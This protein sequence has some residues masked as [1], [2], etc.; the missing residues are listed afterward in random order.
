MN[1]FACVSPTPLI[2]RS[3]L[4]TPGFAFLAT[5]LICGCGTSTEAQKQAQEKIEGYLKTQEVKP[6][7]RKA[8][9]E[10]KLIEGM[11]PEEVKLVMD[12]RP[13]YPRVPSR[14]MEAGRGETWL[15]KGTRWVMPPMVHVVIANGVV[16]TVAAHEEEMIAPSP[17]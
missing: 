15:Y 7:V 13:G 3:P 11:T 6:H 10:R 2:P 8:M 5:L 12:T 1:L 17:K 14:V 4:L 16:A 9:Q